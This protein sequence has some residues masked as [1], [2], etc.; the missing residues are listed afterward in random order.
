MNYLAKILTNSLYGRFGMEDSFI[1][2]AITNEKEIIEFSTNT[3]QEIINIEQL[4]KN[5][6]I[7]IKSK[8]LSF[9]DCNY[10]ETHNINIVIASAITAYARINRSQY[11]NNSNLKLYYTDNDSI[12][13]NLNTYQMN[14]LFPKIINFSEL[15]KLKLETISNKA[16]FISP[17]VYYLKTL[18]NHEIM[19]IKGV[20]KMNNLSETDF[21][22]LLFKD[23]KIEK[24][25]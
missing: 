20:T 14:N 23:I 16:I 22:N 12:Y 11:K 4:D 7:Q 17:K 10:D 1:K 5:Y 15:G 6:L 24:S 9:S 8:I 2:C 25:I 18:D 19:K 3:N 21:D 13:T